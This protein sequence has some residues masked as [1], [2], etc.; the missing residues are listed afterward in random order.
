MNLALLTFHALLYYPFQFDIRSLEVLAE[1]KR[2]RLKLS[3]PEEWWLKKPSRVSEVTHTYWILTLMLLAGREGADTLDQEVQS[4]EVGHR[5][6]TN[7]TLLSLVR[8][9]EMAGGSRQRST[10]IISDGTHTNSIPADMRIYLVSTNA[11]YILESYPIPASSISS[12]I[13]RSFLL[14]FPFQ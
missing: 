13:S 4:F 7:L 8:K 14:L 6:H 9:T 3:E 1:S 12:S 11:L 10:A 2:D 5:E